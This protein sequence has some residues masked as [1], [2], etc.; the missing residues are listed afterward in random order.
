ML[1]VGRTDWTAFPW[2]YKHVWQLDGGC[3]GA[4]GKAA[5]TP[6]QAAGSPQGASA[7]TPKLAKDLLTG[8]G[9]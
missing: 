1:L 7:P 4:A 3:G 5:A 2:G 6:A 9:F 8:P